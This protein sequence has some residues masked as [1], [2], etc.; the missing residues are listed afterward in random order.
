MLG[1]HNP[2]YRQQI[3]ETKKLQGPRINQSRH[4][5]HANS[6]KRG[7]ISKSRRSYPAQVAAIQ[8]YRDWRFFFIF[9]GSIF[10]RTKLWLVRRPRSR[11]PKHKPNIQTRK[12]ILLF[13]IM[14]KRQLQTYSIK[15]VSNNYS[16]NRTIYYSRNSKYFCAMH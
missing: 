15:K 2:K 7:I 9:Q 5:S 1:P 3:I 11:C 13:K 12:T 4:R 6:T 8:E 14:E 16:R 10:I